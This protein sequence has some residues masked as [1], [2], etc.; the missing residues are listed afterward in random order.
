MLQVVG[1]SASFQGADCS[2]GHVKIEHEC[3]SFANPDFVSDL[4]GGSE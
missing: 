2:G 3:G 1:F 4:C